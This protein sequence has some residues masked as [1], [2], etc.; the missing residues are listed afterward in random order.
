MSDTGWVS[1]G[2]VVSD[3]TG[4]GDS[5]ANTGNAVASDDSYAD[6]SGHGGSQGY[7]EYLKA[8][9]FGFSIPEGSTINGIEFRVE[10][11]GGSD[12]FGTD[13][14]DRELKIVKSNGSLGSE[15]KADTVTAGDDYSLANATI[16]SPYFSKVENPQG[17]PTSFELTPTITASSGT[18]TTASGSMEFS[19]KNGLVA[20]SGIIGVTN[21][22]TG[23]GQ[24]R[25]TLPVLPATYGCG[26]GRENSVVGTSVHL[27]IAPSIAY[28]TAFTYSG[29][30]CVVN[31][32]SI[33]FSAS[34]YI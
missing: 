11:Y 25:A 12:Y 17:F 33:R 20:I 28:L 30:S 27:Y 29:G 8:T 2:T 3:S 6:S 31:N 32:Y 15:N 5:W 34:Y 23:S 18:I 14:Y 1:P 4:G 21:I 16:T 7:T 10:K 24:L 9:N 19:I 13:S 26:I 22:G